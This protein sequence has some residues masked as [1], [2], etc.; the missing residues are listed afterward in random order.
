MAVR[1]E[2]AAQGGSV[3]LPSVVSYLRKELGERLTAVIGGVKDASIVR[4]WATGAATPD[5][6]T[7]QALRAAYE[8]TRM[9]LDVDSA[10]TVRLWFG[11]M[12]PE[13]DDQAPA[14]IIAEDPDAV[15]GAARSFVAHG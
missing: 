3:P 14:L 15:L 5:P 11:G 10:E 4:A 12:N 7:E 6:A 1:R 2:P 8:V 13:L 9:L